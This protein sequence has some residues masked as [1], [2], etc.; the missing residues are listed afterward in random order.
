[1]SWLKRERAGIKSKT[2]KEQRPDVPE[3][4]WTKCEGC[5]EALFQTVLDENL[6]TCP[7]CN[8]HFR[9]PARTYLGYVVD[10][11]SFEERFADLEAGD[12]LEFRDAKMR[13]PERLKLA[14]RD[15]GMKDAALS[16]VAS[17]GGRPV[18][19]TIMDFFFMGGSMGSVVGEK[20]ARSIEA[21]IS[22]RRALI[23][24]SATG[25]ARMQEG[26]LSLMQMAK[27]SAL[28]ARLQDE[29]LPFISILTDPSTAGV[30]ASYA[31]L[32]D[33]ILAEPGALVGFA[34][35]RVIRQTIGEDLPP[36]F[37]RAEFVLEKGFIDRIVHRKQMREEVTRLLEFFWRST[38]GFAAAGQASP[39]AFDPELPAA[40]GRPRPKPASG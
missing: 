14:Q 40:D 2:N 33:V 20:V 10:P 26:I 11:G 3:G 30:L 9:V 22:E 1:M 25:G 16:G 34:G 31:S 15:T 28:L 17:V 27:T 24:V 19:L 12:P 39:H 6:W 7:K 23:V 35:A 38:R 36:G 8:F 18:S 21:A 32:G 5:G 29:R 13:Y 4:L 37:Q